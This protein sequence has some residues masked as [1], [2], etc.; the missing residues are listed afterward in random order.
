MALDPR[1]S[2]IVY[3]CSG[4]A[5]LAGLL[6]GAIPGS[7]LFFLVTIWSVGSFLIIVTSSETSPLSFT[8]RLLLAVLTAAFALGLGTELATLVALPI[9]WIVNPLMNFFF[10]Y[11]VLRAFS[12]LFARQD[13][14][15]ITSSV[16]TLFASIL[17]M[18]FGGDPD[19]GDARDS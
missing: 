5:A 2:G 18:I 7:D 8:I 9:F 15:E 16:A 6:F 17:R 13:P 14:E 10:T 19:V 12:K 3:V 11:R 4:L 1:H